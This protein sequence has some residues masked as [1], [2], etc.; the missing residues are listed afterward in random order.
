VVHP[1]PRHPAP[2]LDRESLTFEMVSVLCQIVP[3]AVASFHAFGRSFFPKKGPGVA[4]GLM[5]EFASPTPFFSAPLFS[6]AP[7]REVKLFFILAEL[8]LCCVEL[9]Y[10]IVTPSFSNFFFAV[11]TSESNLPKTE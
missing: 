8:T 6:G 10:A 5:E 11:L 2:L 9:G 7:S 1:P 3:L 4:D